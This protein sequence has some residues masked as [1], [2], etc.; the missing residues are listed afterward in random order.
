MTQSLTV[1]RITATAK[2]NVAT[3]TCPTLELP[4][5]NNPLKTR[6]ETN[7]RL[8]LNIKL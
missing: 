4:G 1:I 6:K 3:T 2:M 8:N 5:P 7:A